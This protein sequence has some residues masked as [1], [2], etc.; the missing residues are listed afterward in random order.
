MC[1]FGKTPG[2]GKRTK[3]GG[4][5]GGD[6]GDSNC[7]TKG[8]LSLSS[9][10]WMNPEDKLCCQMCTAGLCLETWR[11]QSMAFYFKM[12]CCMCMRNGGTNMWYYFIASNWRLRGEVVT[13]E[14]FCSLRYWNTLLVTVTLETC[15]MATR[16]NLPRVN[17]LYT[18]NAY[19]ICHTLNARLPKFW[20]EKQ[21]Y[22]KNE[23]K[24]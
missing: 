8:N 3:T 19:T 22:S 2:A 9:M 13:P 5:Y 14:A 11:S 4:N 21:P 6:D 17:T 20:S 24:V 7:E 1:L 12:I 10:L 16:H 15:I 23:F 18:R